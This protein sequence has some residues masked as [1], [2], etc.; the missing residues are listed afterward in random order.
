MATNAAIIAAIDDAILAWADQP[1]SLSISGRT[2][3]YR[4]LAE[5][6]DARKY[7]A[8]LATTAS[9]GRGF[10]IKHFKAGGSRS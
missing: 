9:V 8:Q 7:Y 10:T 1:V 3:T 5:L 6:I 4:S 2:I